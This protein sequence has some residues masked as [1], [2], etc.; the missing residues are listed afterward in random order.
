MNLPPL[1][2]PISPWLEQAWLQRY[3]DRE[4]APEEVAWFEAY[5]LDKPRLLDAIEADN[6]LR[7]VMHAAGPDIDQALRNEAASCFEQTRVESPEPPPYAVS[8]RRPDAR[9]RS[10]LGS[11]MALAASFVGGLGLASVLFTEPRH[12]MPAEPDAEAPARLVFDLL[13]GGQVELREDAGDPQARLMVVDIALPL[14]SRIAAA[15]AELGE[16]RVELPAARISVEG[17][18]TYTLPRSWR[19]RAQLHFDLQRDGG[20]A[21]PP[22]AIAL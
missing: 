12:A 10:R 2:L 13:R 21:L 5:L 14:G 19:G 6:A 8:A 17:F 1:H 16:R 4:L 22:V 18:A 7:A 11:L 20:D 9:S 3:L 15:R